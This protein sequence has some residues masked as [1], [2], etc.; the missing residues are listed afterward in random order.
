MKAAQNNELETK[1]EFQG[2]DVIQHS[3]KRIKKKII[4]FI[5][6]NYKS[7]FFAD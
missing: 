7:L 2:K 6:L 3:T 4:D 5:L 1:D